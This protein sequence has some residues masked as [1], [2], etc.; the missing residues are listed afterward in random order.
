MDFSRV[1]PPTTGSQRNLTF[2]SHSDSY[3]FTS[4]ISKKIQTGA[5]FIFLMKPVDVIGK[6]SAGGNVFISPLSSRAAQQLI[7]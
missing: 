5:M 7:M 1:R 4:Q 2:L 3:I 6:L